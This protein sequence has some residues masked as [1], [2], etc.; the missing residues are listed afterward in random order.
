MKG[1]ADK[2]LLCAPLDLPEI[3]SWLHFELAPH[4]ADT[5]AEVLTQGVPLPRCPRMCGQSQQEA[6]AKRRSVTPRQSML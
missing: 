4:R 2:H 1:L 5:F 3:E 6:D